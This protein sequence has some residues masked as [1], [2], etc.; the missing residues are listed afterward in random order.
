MADVTACVASGS[1]TWVKPE[2]SAIMSG[3]VSK[4]PERKLKA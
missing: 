4:K 2:A 1:V 3:P